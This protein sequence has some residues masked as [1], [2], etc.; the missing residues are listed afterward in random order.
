MDIQSSSRGSRFQIVGFCASF[1][2]IS[3]I[4]T[5]RTTLSIISPAF[6]RVHFYYE[7]PNKN[8]HAQNEAKMFA[9]V[10][11]PFVIEPISS[12]LEQS[13]IIW[14]LESRDELWMSIFIRPMSHFIKSIKVDTQTIPHVPSMSRRVGLGVL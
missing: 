10:V 12:K 5:D 13:L 14:I 6:E 4:G 11:Q 9:T 7:T 2:G 1:D 8:G 3:S